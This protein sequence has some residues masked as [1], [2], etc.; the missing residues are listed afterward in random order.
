MKLNLGCGN[1]RL[2][3]WINVDREAVL[4]PDQIW[5]LERTPWPWADSSVDEILLIHV[6]EH[7]GQ[8]T[9]TFLAIIKELWRVCRHDARITIEVPH[10]R[11]DSF[12]SDP[13]HVRPILPSMLALFDQSLNRE[14]VERK[15]SNT[16][17]GL[18]LGVDFRVES[19]SHLPAEPWRSRLAAGEID[20]ATIEEAYNR[21]N[22]VIEVV[23]IHW[24]VVKPGTG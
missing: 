22:N 18:I 6:L 2:D 15:L 8:Q 3:G 11:H 5:D 4:K 9:N 20:R 14:W 23:T 17:L 10:P 1:S 12:L 13:T 16:S 7:L 24:R 19:F 21:F